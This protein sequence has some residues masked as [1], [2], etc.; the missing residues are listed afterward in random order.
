M[1]TVSELA[2]RSGAT[3]HAV[4]YYTRM[5]L[6]RPERNPDNGYH[7]YKPREINWLRFIRQAKQLGYTLNE[8]KAIMHDADRGQ[9]PCPRVREILQRRI[10]ENRRHLEE[11]IDLQTRME[12]ALLEW[13]DKPDGVPDGHSVCHLIESFSADIGGELPNEHITT[14][15]RRKS[16][17]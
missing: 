13:A 17:H 1:L 15:A 2:N 16:N 12:E 11:L 3:P 10:V 4:R 6:L 5:G 14:D 8:V 7:L 9:S